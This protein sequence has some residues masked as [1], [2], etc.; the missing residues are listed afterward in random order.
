MQHNEILTCLKVL[1]RLGV[2]SNSKMMQQLLHLLKDNLNHLSISQLAFFNLLIKQMQPTPLGD[3][4]LIAV[5]V[6]F[7]LQ[8]SD[9]I[10]H[11]NPEEIQKIFHHVTMSEMKIGKKEL[12]NIITALAI[13]GDS[14]SLNT[15][16][17][18]MI[19]L[20][21]LPPEIIQEQPALKLVANC[22]SI[23]NSP[24]CIFTDFNHVASVVFKMIM[25]YKESRILSIFYNPKLFD[26]VAEMVIQD[27]L[28]FDK[29]FQLISAF[30]D[31]SFVNYSLLDYIDKKIIQ[32]EAIL[33]T[34]ELGKL[35]VLISAL[36]NANYRTENWEILKSIL[37]ENSVFTEEIP[38]FIPILKM[39]VELMS[40]DFISR[41]LLQKVLNPEFLGEHLRF[42]S[43]NKN[44]SALTNLRVLSQTLSILHPEHADLLPPKVFLDIAND[45]I[46]EK[47]NEYHRE[48]LEFIYG[49]HNVLTN[50]R[51]AYGH[52]L[53]F[54]INFDSSKRPVEVSKKIKNYEELPTHKLQPVAICFQSH[55]H[56]PVN[57]PIRF[58]SIPEMRRRSL[59]KIGIK[60]VVI[61]TYT[62]ESLPDAEKCAFIEREIS[63]GGVVIPDN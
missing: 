44:F 6:V 54:V 10:D 38:V 23:M 35:R 47:T 42:F 63:E 12:L 30:N 7:S 37:H 4:L 17:S 39:T 31:I 9:Q 33:K 1:N 60:E 41:I 43:K 13:H 19:S 49:S 56:C 8:I 20:S 59:E 22:L 53:D 16:T 25:R 11:E 55:Q 46:T 52:R 2:R 21:R 40:L 45:R 15:A 27:D 61:P 62:L 51:T 18:C 14:L 3:A 5:P 26:K 48:M 32:N 24:Q 36:S 34:M 28:G 29:A 58:K 50:I 57:F